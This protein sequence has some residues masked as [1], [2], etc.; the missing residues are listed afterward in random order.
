[1]S[2]F[3]WRLE[4]F[5]EDLADVSED[6]K[7]IYSAERA[8]VQPFLVERRR[9]LLGLPARELRRFASNL[10]LQVPNLGFSLSR[11]KLMLPSFCLAVQV[12]APVSLVENC[13]P[14]LAKLRN[15]ISGVVLIPVI[16][17]WKL[18]VS[19]QNSNFIST[20]DDVILLVIDTLKDSHS[21]VRV[22]C[23]F[24]TSVRGRLKCIDFWRPLKVSYF[25]LN[26]INEGYKIPFVHLR[27]PFSKAAMLP[28]VLTSFVF[29]A[30]PVNSGLIEEMFCVPDIVN[31]LSVSTRSSGKQRL[32][33][34]LR[35]ENAFI[36]KQK[37]K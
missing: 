7:C 24:Q 22:D 6:K 26:V 15:D 2:K 20:C 23:S 19:D 1:M 32:T 16:Y 9:P 33:L 31:P 36:Y 37:L 8:P 3:G 4:N 28:H 27:T 11:L 12:W 17:F 25:I 18:A 14:A 5:D 35:H 34:D 30:Q 21:I 10:C 29:Q 13:C